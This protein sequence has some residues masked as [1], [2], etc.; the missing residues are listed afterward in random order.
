M[1]YN[2]FLRYLAAGKY[3]FILGKLSNYKRKA[4]KQFKTMYF[5]LIQTIL[6]LASSIGALP[7]ISSTIPSNAKTSVASYYGSGSGDS[8]VD[9]KHPGSCGKKYLP[10]G[11]YKDYYV[12]LPSSQFKSQ[13]GKCLQVSYKGKS[14]KVYV[15]DECPSCKGKIDLS[16]KAFSKIAG[17]TS[18]SKRLGVAKGIKYWSVPC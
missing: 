11:A 7:A 16:F 3:G 9:A 12:A 1:F 13:C 2:Q 8:G 5:Y 18:A 14:V 15:T 17:G 10:S 4:V 6:I